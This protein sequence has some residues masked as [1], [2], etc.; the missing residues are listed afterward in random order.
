MKS[1]S[2]LDTAQSDLQR[3]RKPQVWCYRSIPLYTQQASGKLVVFKK[4]GV[5]LAEMGYKDG[6]LPKDLFVLRGR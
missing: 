4:R 6:N 2:V 5:T 3:V 1:S